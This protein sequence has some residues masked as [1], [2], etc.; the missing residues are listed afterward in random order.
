MKATLSELDLTPTKLKIQKI[1]RKISKVLIAT[2]LVALT[3]NSLMAQVEKGRWMIGGAAGYNSNKVEDAD[4]STST[5][6]IGPSIGHFFMDNLAAG[7]NIGFTS[8]S[9][10]GESASTVGI[11]PFVR[12]YLPM[13][14]FGQLG[15][16]FN[17]TDYGNDAKSTGGTLR[18]AAGYGLFLNDN[19]AI[20]PTIYYGMNSEKADG[21]DESVKSS[22]FGVMIGIQAFIGG[23]K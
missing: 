14:V 3:S 8:V 10:D 1:M 6:Y 16:D 9:Y 5:I 20:E 17:S 19:I 23:G 7:L 15:Y 11:G 2:V 21:A 4:A 22:D 13:K 12:Y 18:I